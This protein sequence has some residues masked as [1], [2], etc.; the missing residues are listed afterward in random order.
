M[1]SSDLGVSGDVDLSFDDRSFVR[2]YTITTGR[3]IGA[4]GEIPIETLVVASKSAVGL[5]P[6]H[7]AVVE[8]CS[9]AQPF[10][11][12]EIALHLDLPLGVARVLVADLTASGHVEQH[13]TMAA[14]NDELVRRLLE[15]IRSL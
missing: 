14:E 5:Q 12:V 7:A 10:S 13:D 6:D 8:L 3:T 11:V 9:E 2:P 4:A 1:T 15:G